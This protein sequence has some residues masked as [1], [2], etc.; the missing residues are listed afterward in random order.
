[1][2]KIAI[3]DYGFWI[4]VTTC[5]AY[6]NPLGD[7]IKATRNIM[8]LEADPNQYLKSAGEQMLRYKQLILDWKKDYRAKLL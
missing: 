7:F 1:M 4:W 5:R 6:D 8:Q 3:K 2:K